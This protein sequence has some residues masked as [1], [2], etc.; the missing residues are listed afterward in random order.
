[1][2]MIINLMSLILKLSMYSLFSITI[3]LFIFL[4]LSSNKIVG[5]NLCILCFVLFVYLIL[6]EK[7]RSNKKIIYN[8][9]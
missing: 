2:K 8:N 1:M 3:L 9:N 6:Y 5:G 4:L 7:Y